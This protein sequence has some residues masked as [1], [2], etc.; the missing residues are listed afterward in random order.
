MECWGSPQ[1][2]PNHVIDHIDRNKLNNNI[3]NLRWLTKSENK[4]N[5]DKKLNALHNS[6]GQL[7]SQKKKRVPVILINTKTNEKFSF[8]S[9]FKAA[10]W[11]I[12]TNQTNTKSPTGLARRIAVQK[13]VHG[14]KIH[15]INAERPA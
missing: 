12:E 4:N 9:R 13:F 6:I 15:N 14:Y 8:T 11:L 10:Q 1:P 2:S 3:E 5:T 7:N